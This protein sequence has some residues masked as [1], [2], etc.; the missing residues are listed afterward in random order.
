MEWNYAIFFGIMVVEKK[1][2]INQVTDCTLIHYTCVDLDIY[3]QGS[4]P[5]PVFGD[6]IKALH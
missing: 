1:V 6:G 5:F 2:V 3:L 4:F